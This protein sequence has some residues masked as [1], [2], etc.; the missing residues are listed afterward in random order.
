MSGGT[1]ETLEQHTVC[2]LACRCWQGA[3]PLWVRAHSP[4]GLEP[5]N[6]SYATIAS[7]YYQQHSLSRIVDF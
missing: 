2:S 1:G 6:L 3:T 4:I 5:P 7:E